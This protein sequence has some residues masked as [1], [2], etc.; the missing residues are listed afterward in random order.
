MNKLGLI[1]ALQ[2]DEGCLILK[3]ITYIY[4]YI[5]FFKFIFVCIFI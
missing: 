4:I 1:E 5:F 3:L 2:L